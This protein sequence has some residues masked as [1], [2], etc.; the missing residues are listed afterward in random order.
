M[1]SPRLKRNPLWPIVAL[2]CTS[3]LA[4]ILITQPWSLR[5][6]SLPLK[7]GDVAPQDLL[8]P[9]NVTYVST[10]LTSEAQTEAEQEV[11]P[12]YAAPDPSIA[13]T[14][15]DQLNDL[16]RSISSIRDDPQ[17]TLDQKRTSLLSIQNEILSPSSVSL[18]L[19][20]DDPTW[21]TVSSEAVSLLSRVMENPVRTE[22]IPTLQQGLLA[23]VSYTLTEQQADLVVELVSPYLAANSF[24]SPDLTE[25][26]RQAARDAV[27]PVTQT[28]LQDQ[29][30]VTR[31]QLITDAQLEALTVMDLVQPADPNNQMIGAAALVAILILVVVLYFLRRPTLVGDL[32][33]VLLLAILFVGFLAAVRVVIPNRTIVPYIFPVPAFA[34]LVAALY[35]VEN[36]VIFGLMMAVLSAYG[37]PDALWLMPYYVVSSLCGV[38]A[39]GQARRVTQFL[40]AAAA[41]SAAGIAVLIAFRLPFTQTD[42]IGLAT[43]CGAAVICGIGSAA[44]VLPLQ[45]LLAQFLGLTTPIQ[46]L[47]ISRPES[48]LLVYFLQRAPGTYQHSLQVANL[49]EQAADAIGADALLTRVGAFIHDVGKAANPLFFIENQPPSQLDSHDEMPPEQSAATVIRHVSDGLKLARK[50]R[51]PRRLHDFIAE[52]HGTLITR[53]Q[54]NR[55]LKAAGGNAGSVEESA[56][57]YPGPKPRSK[58]T[59]LL[60]FADGVEARARAERPKDDEAMRFL[61]RDVIELCQKDGQLDDAPL[62]QSDLTK[63]IDSFVS[64]LRVTYHPRLEYPK[65]QL[66]PA[67]VPTPLRSAEKEK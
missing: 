35:G 11:A 17:S 4:Y 10:V 46:L 67:E 49:A 34:L 38:L 29:T 7:V 39:L 23:Q 31:G 5:Q 33:S 20:M 25:T 41:T 44:V 50:Y 2:V 30:I 12:V 48:P 1:E 27:Q 22:D 43:L 15:I 32:R 18:L 26:A 40:Y 51:L 36:G 58:E 64:T 52:H 54:Y 53:Y 59:A 57:R 6:A 42:W 28:Y 3:L 60:M 21:G 8:A 45:Y 9:R 24:Y 14:Q 55:A 63:V 19:S 13:R 62:S 16:I 37:Q 47:D 66:S 61:A 65:D 56:F